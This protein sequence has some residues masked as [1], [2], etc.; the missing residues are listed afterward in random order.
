M[1]ILRAGTYGLA[2]LQQAP[3]HGSWPTVGRSRLPKSERKARIALLKTRVLALIRKRAHSVKQ[4]Q[5]IPSLDAYETELRIVL[6]E[7]MSENLA[8][9]SLHK[10]RPFYKG[11]K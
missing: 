7:L 11:I 1:S 5:A 2:S 4:L 6:A 3:K 8:T 10:G 9:K